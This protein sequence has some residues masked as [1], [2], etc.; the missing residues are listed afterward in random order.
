MNSLEFF[1]ELNKS[2]KNQNIHAVPILDLKEQLNALRNEIL[3]AVTEVIDSTQYIMGSKIEVLEQAI[4]DYTGTSYG[5]GVSSGT[6]A[7]LL[8]LMA[9]N[10]GPGDR[11]ITSDFS[12]I[13]TA[14]VI[15][16]QYAIPLFVDID[17]FTFNICPDKLQQLLW[18]MTNRE[19]NKVKAIIPVHL[20]GQCAEMESL[21]A[22][23]NE[24]QIPLIEDA[25]QAIGAEYVLSGEVKRAGAMGRMGCFSFFPS[26]N[27]GGIGDAGMVVTNDEQLAL[28]L[29]QKRVHGES[30]QYHH[31]AV[32][33]NFRMDPIQA[34]VLSV[35]LPFLDQWHQARQRNA[36][37]YSDLFRKNEL[38]QI[39]LPTAIYKNRN[40]VN[41]HIYNQ[42]VIRVPQRDA[43]Q[44]YLAQHQ[45]ETRV[46]YP[47]PLHQQGC[48]QSLGYRTGDF[49]ESEKAAQ[50]VLALPVYPELTEVMQEYV[51]E[52]ISEF[53]WKS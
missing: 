9:L 50:E 17:P 36:E 31:N 5:V 45:I 14:A 42:F 28:L 25:G 38:E 52:K 48:F 7:L 40:L 10:V 44:A 13:A 46:Y 47:L 21:F 39:L 12:F 26:K 43:L 27:L 32:G 15:S 34:A 19:R 24:Y 23:A 3:N 4:A 37:R 35:K 20:Y 22:V 33:G 53:Y 29:K 1:S 2:M 30:S 6:D 16:R 18:Q 8:S 11:V 41:P 49:P 51:V